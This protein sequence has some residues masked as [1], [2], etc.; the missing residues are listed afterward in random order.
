MASFD[1]LKTYLK[2][3]KDH[4][5]AYSYNFLLGGLAGTISVSLTYPTD[6]VRRKLQMVGKPGFPHYDG[7]FDCCRKIM[8]EDGVRGFYLGLVPCLAKVAPA[9]ALMFWC[10]ELLKDLFGRD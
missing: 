5:R 7:I 10:N 2:I 4:P 6:L 9:M 8:V 3:D 1:I